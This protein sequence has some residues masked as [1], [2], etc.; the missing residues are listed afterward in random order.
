MSINP[1]NP[2]GETSP[3]VHPDEREVYADLI[4]WCYARRL[5]DVP[6]VVLDFARAQI[7]LQSAEGDWPEGF[8]ASGYHMR[9]HSLIFEAV[10]AFVAGRYWTIE[11]VLRQAVPRHMRKE[12]DNY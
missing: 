5:F 10:G 6:P 8:K 7:I 11:K 1:N 4:R 12:F 3:C 9:Q 2:I